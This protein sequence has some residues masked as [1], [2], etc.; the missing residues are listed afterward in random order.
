MLSDWERSDR[1]RYKKVDGKR[2]DA[3]YVGY[4]INHLIYL[5]ASDNVSD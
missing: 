4:E 5:T 1:A 2:V 3:H